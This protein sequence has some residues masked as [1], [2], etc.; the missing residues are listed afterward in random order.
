MLAAALVAAAAERAPGQCGGQ[1]CAGLWAGEAKM[2]LV[3]D[4]NPIL[5]D[6]GFD[7]GI[8]GRLVQNYFVQAGAANWAYL[9]TTSAAAVANYTL[10][11]F[12]G[13]WATATAP[14]GYGETNLATVIS[15]TNTVSTFLRKSFVIS[16]ATNYDL[17]TIRLQYDDGAVLYLNGSQIAR[18]NMPTLFS[19]NTPALSA[20]DGSNEALYVTLTTP[21]TLLREG[22]NVVAVEIHQVQPTNSDMRFDLEMYATFK[23]EAALTLLPVQSADWRYLATGASLSGTNWSTLAYSETGWATNGVAPLGYGNGGDDVTVLPAGPSTSRWVTASF[24]RKFLVGSLAQQSHLDF[25][26][27]RDDGAV[28]YVNGAEVFRSNLPDGPIDSLTEPVAPVGPDTEA[29]YNVTRVNLQDLNL[30]AGTNQVAVEVHQHRNELGSSFANLATPVA[31][32]FDVRLL[33]HV[34]SNGTARF[35]KEVT[36]MWKDGTYAPAGG[37]QVVNTPGHFVLVTDDAKL[38]NFSGIALRDGRKV[39]R[40]MSTIGFD[41][42]SNH[43]DMVG[44]LSPDG[45][46]SFTNRIEPNFRTN[47]YRHKFHPDHDNL[48]ARYENFVEEA[49]DIT[50]VITLDFQTNYPPSPFPGSVTNESPAAWGFSEIGGVYNEKLTGLHKNE[51]E[52]IG[53]FSLK[54]VTVV[55]KLNDE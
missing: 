9:A 27:R 46:L 28:V 17:V 39:G 55:D 44:T 42:P 37:G 32:P 38:A 3:S 5:P 26:L 19:V 45:Q 40:R 7:L 22:T 10:D 51:I 4:A 52:V 50:R 54:R 20:L 11:S 47:P 31:E 14:L 41:F 21:A 43:L 29:N 13:V 8:E 33:I 34:D 35:L 30:V 23:N 18:Q 36:Q 53:S 1:P 6:F 12:T 24:R 48:D 25:L 49:F 2:L 15:P 16:N